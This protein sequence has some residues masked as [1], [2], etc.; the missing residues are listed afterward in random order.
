[1]DNTSNDFT[2][3]STIEKMQ[4]SK[5]SKRFNMATAQLKEK[6]M[7]S[8]KEIKNVF[9]ERLNYLTII[10]FIIVLLILV[11]FIFIGYYVPNKDIYFS[12]IQYITVFI[13]F[14]ILLSFYLANKPT[15]NQK[16][17]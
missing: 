12:M 10:V 1:M 2:E 15:Y 7:N 13:F 14:L 3:S 5:T 16:N 9:K 17:Q 11:F 4:N 6:I 8:V